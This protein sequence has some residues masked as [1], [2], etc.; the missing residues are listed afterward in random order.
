MV[1]IGR[2]FDGQLGKVALP[3]AVWVSLLTL[4]SLLLLTGGI[5]LA[6]AEQN[7]EW[8]ARSGA[9]IEALTVMISFLQFWCDEALQEG[10]TEIELRAQ[11]TFER[12]FYQS[13]H[14]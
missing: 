14:K 12:H 13:V 9:A 1:T 4:L 5:W 2:L 3:G 10:W 7:S 8:I 11:A 6:I